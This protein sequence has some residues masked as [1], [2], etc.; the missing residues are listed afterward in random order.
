MG[1]ITLRI[2]EDVLDR[3][4]MRASIAG[5]SVEEEIG[6]IVEEATA[7]PPPDRSAL[8]EEFRQIRA[9]TPPGAPIDVAAVIREGRER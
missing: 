7:A 5:R 4:K 6:R 8:V 1:E 2:E 3:L 9:L